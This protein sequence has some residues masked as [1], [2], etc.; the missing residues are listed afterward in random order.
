MNECTLQINFSE[1]LKNL[2]LLL[3]VSG[4]Y[5]GVLFYISPDL[6]LFWQ[7]HFLMVILF[8]PT[9]SIHVS[10]LIK[11]YGDKYAVSETYIVDKNRN[12][13]FDQNSIFK[14]QVYKYS[15][16]PFGFHFLP[17]HQYS[18]CKVILKNGE[19][20]ILT[21]L[22]KFNIDNF[23]KDKLEGVVYETCFKYFPMI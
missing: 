7:S 9:I 10:Y 4:F 21:S 13:K 23:L 8:I 20:F 22:L 12:L 16:P 15:P 3:L 14:I 18:F 11:N 17:F 19:S 6:L 2:G 1:Q 5:Y